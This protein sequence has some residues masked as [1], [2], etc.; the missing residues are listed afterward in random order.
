MAN[1]DFDIAHRLEEMSQWYVH[2][3]VEKIRNQIAEEAYIEI[4][5]LR[6]ENKYLRNRIK[7]YQDNESR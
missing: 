1:K 7:E 5:K 3:T 2:N 6:E 4:I